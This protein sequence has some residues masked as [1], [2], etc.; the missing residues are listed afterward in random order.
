M[1]K[2]VIIG[3]GQVGSSIAFTLTQSSLVQEIVIIDINKEKAEGDALDLSHGV[4]LSFS[5]IIKA[6]EYKDI[7]E[8]KVIILAC[9]VGQ[10]PNETRI[11]LLE[12]NKKVFSSV[13]SNMKP[14]IEKDAIVLVVSNPV[15][16]LSYYVSTKLGLPTSQIIGSGTV[17]DSARL[18][19]LISKDVNIDPRS[20]HAYVIGEHGD[21]EVIALSTTS[22]GGIKVED[23]YLS[24]GICKSDCSSRLNKI[25]NDVRTSA[26]EI[27]K[28][29]GATYY[30]IALATK[31][32]L[33][34]IFNDEH[35][36]LTVSSYIVEGLDGK[37]NDVYLSVP[38]II[39]NSGIIDILH[40]NYNDEEKERLIESAKKLKKLL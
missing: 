37:I 23:Y 21:S 30:G 8:A 32:I 11:E 38:C 10:K 2:V 5:K 9:G 19:Y 35:S 36:I 29:K 3:D 25:C 33:E 24:K 6:G 12:R 28:M 31:R 15:D 34:A 16:I 26:N 7:K 18:K 20:I 4:A 27:I 39:G 1:R 14:Y 17:L 40:P 22:I 13:I